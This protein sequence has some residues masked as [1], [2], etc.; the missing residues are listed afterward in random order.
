MPSDLSGRFHPVAP[1]PLSHPFPTHPNQ[2]KN[3][4]D[5]AVLSTRRRRAAGIV[6]QRTPRRSCSV[7]RNYPLRAT[8]QVL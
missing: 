7:R 8:R 5:Q 2:G 1:M 6:V 4:V 3:T